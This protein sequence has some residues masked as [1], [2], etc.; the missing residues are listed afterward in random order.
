M[1]KLDKTDSVF[2]KLDKLDK[3]DEMEK[4]V[5]T[6]TVKVKDTENRITKS[7]SVTQ[8]LQQSVLFMSDQFDSITK[9]TVNRP[10]CA[11]GP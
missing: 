9:T 3:L 7:E 10:S 5:R 8:E 1:S 4:N 2:S 11:C 6:I